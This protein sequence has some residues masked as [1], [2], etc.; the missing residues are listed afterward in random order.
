M[1][2]I[3]KRLEAQRLSDDAARDRKVERAAKLLVPEYSLG[4]CTRAYCHNLPPDA[5][6][7]IR[8]RWAPG[9]LHEAN[10]F[11]LKDPA[12]PPSSVLCTAILQGGTV[13]DVDYALQNGGV[14]FSYER[15]TQTKRKV[16]ICEK[17]RRAHPVLTKCIERAASASNSNWQLLD[18]WPAFASALE[19]CNGPHL[20]VTSRRPKF[21]LAVTDKTTADGMKRDSIMQIWD[22]LSFLKKVH[23]VKRNVCNL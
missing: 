1:V 22:F 7:K 16:L 11:V 15:A 2:T 10:L 20:K 13:A 21:V 23:S 3:A 18:G 9:L 19:A 4:R 17:A 5:E 8:S 14:A 12:T 6:A